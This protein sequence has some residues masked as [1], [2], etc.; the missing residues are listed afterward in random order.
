MSLHRTPNSFRSKRKKAARNKKDFRLDGLE[1]RLLLSAYVFD[2]QFTGTVGSGPPAAWGPENATDPNNSKVYYT[3]T[4]PA[5]ATVNNPATMQIVNDP[6]SD[7][8]QALAMT[9]EPAP[10][11]TGDYVSSEIA[12]Q[13]DP[14]GA[15]NSL[16]YGEIS[17]RIRLPG[18]SN[19]N[20]IWPAFWMLGDDITSVGW[21]ASGEID[22]MENR[23]SA[24]GTNDSTLHGPASGGGDYNGGDGV[25]SSYTLPGGADFYSEL[26]HLLGELGTQLRHLFR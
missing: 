9:L 6:T 23:G 13:F 26:S 7:D 25:G 4:I 5:N 21:P 22:I 15:G 12:T 20:A 17:A 19:S 24:P 3:N 2:T 14:S 10:N 18:G 16:E 1:P 11:G 8:G